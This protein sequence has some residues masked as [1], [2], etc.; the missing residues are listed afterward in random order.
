MYI[1]NK[2]PRG[3]TIIILVMDEWRKTLV[4]F[5]ILKK[6]KQL[7]NAC[8]ILTIPIPDLFEIYKFSVHFLSSIKPES[9]LYLSNAN[10]KTCHTTTKLNYHTVV[11]LKNSQF[12]QYI[13]RGFKTNYK[14]YGYLLKPTCTSKLCTGTQ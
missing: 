9:P 5:I 3:V 4:S 2:D 7:L 1:K 14:N 11:I 8:F 13:L 10:I 6:L 12:R